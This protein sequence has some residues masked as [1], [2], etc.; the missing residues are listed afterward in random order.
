MWKSHWLNSE[1]KWPGL[2]LWLPAT[3]NHK[4]SGPWQALSTELR[5][6]GNSKKSHSRYLVKA[7]GTDFLEFL[8]FQLLPYPSALAYKTTFNDRVVSFNCKWNTGSLNRNS[9]LA[10][11]A[12]G[13]LKARFRVAEGFRFWRHHGMI[14]YWQQLVKSVA[15]EARQP[16]PDGPVENGLWAFPCTM[17]ITRA[18]KGGENGCLSESLMSSPF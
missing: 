14:P 18:Y 8:P 15:E 9:F 2:Q 6:S 10:S 11:I 5:D 13:D 7:K 3:H 1:F 17:K 4:P 12:K 16:L